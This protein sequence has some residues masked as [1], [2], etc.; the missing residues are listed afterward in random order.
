MYVC[1]SV[2]VASIKNKHFCGQSS[3]RY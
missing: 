2:I 1:N 3:R